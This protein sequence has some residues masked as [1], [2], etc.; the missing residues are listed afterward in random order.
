MF[1]L[2]FAAL[3]SVAVIFEDAI[4]QFLSQLLA[5]SSHAANMKYNYLELAENY[6]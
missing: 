1:A 4:F 5:G 2:L 6:E 3:L